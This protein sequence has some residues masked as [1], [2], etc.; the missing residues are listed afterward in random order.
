MNA[1]NRII[2]LDDY[3]EV[4]YNDRPSAWKFNLV[5]DSNERKEETENAKN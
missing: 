5:K 2:Y 3:P 1:K 4:S